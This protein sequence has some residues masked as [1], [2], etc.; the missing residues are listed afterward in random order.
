VAFFS[1]ILLL[2]FGSLTRRED[3]LQRKV[4]SALGA[5]LV[6]LVAVILVSSYRRLALYEDAYGFTG[7]RLY[8]HVFILWLGLLL[9]ATAALEVAGRI[10]WFSAAAI[11]AAFGFT[12]TLAVLNVDSSIVRMNGLRSVVLQE[13]GANDRIEEELDTAYFARLS[14]DAVPELLSLYETGAQPDK[15]RIGAGLSCRLARMEANRADDWQ[16]YV[17]PVAEALRLL[18]ASS[19]AETYPVYENRGTFFVTVGGEEERCPGQ[20]VWMD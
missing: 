20:D 5:F 1:L 13:T 19:V 9:A 14:A 16:S 11:S 12:L 15:D 4:F 10:R 3:P 6:A 18:R 8:T 7:L 17:R 2:G